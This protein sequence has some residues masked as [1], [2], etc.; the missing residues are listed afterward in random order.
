MRRRKI[1]HSTYVQYAILHLWYIV[2]PNFLVLEPTTLIH[3]YIIIIIV[4][5]QRKDTVTRIYMV[6]GILKF[7]EYLD[8]YSNSSECQLNANGL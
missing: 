2:Q 3:V 5:N 1:L 4:Y 8:S 7:N 6:L